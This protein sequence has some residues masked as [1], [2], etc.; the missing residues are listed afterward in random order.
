VQ[1]RVSRDTWQA[2]QLLAIDGRPAA[3]VAAKLRL[4]VAAAYAARHR[5]QK[6][7]AEE[8]QKLGG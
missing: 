1:L 5:V 3:E 7:L 4:K 2:F 8:I 6:M